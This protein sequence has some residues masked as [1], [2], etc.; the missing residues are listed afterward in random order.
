MISIWLIICILGNVMDID[1]IIDIEDLFIIIFNG[2]IIVFSLIIK[3][4]LY[5]LICCIYNK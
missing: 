1:V 4:F 3:V 2:D 5:Y